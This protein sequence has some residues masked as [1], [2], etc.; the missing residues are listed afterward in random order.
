MEDTSPVS[1]SGCRAPPCLVRQGWRE[2]GS[3]VVHTC[4]VREQLGSRRAAPD[5]WVAQRRAAQRGPWT[6]S[7]HRQADRSALDRRRRGTQGDRAV[8]II[9]NPWGTP[10]T[11]VNSPPTPWP[12]MEKL[13]WQPRWLTPIS[14]GS[15]GTAGPVH[16]K[17]DRTCTWHMSIRNSANRFMPCWGYSKALFAMKG[18]R[19][20][21]SRLLIQ[22]VLMH[23]SPSRPIM[24]SGLGL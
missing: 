2:S 10:V 7:R 6:R 11:A 12:E 18:L 15:L 19:T 4:L 8:C 20:G 16:C 9:I 14:A 22:N 5:M 21:Q 23:D 13:F 24:T 17:V 1:V 3:L